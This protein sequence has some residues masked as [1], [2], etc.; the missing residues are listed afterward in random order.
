MQYFTID[1][2][3]FLDLR[4]NEFATADVLFRMKSKKRF[5]FKLSFS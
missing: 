4:S 2:Y 1:N 3:K 5:F